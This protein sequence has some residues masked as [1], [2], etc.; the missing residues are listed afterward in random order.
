MRRASR[1]EVSIARDGTRLH[2]RVTDNGV[3][4]AATA[5]ASTEGGGAGFASMRLR[6]QRLGALLKIDDASPGTTLWL[7]MPLAA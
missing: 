7:E 2:L 6:A 5:H 4:L 1:V 3:G